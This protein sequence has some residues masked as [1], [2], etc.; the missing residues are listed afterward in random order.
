MKRDHLHLEIIHDV[1]HADRFFA[2]VSI[3]QPL[4]EA[5]YQY[6]L[7]THQIDARTHGFAKGTTPLKY[8]EHTIKIPILKQL[9][10]FFLKHLVLGFLYRELRAK[11]IVTAGHPRL[12]NITM[13]PEHNALFVFEM[14]QVRQALKPDWKAFSFKAPMRKN[15][16]D[17][18]RQADIFIKEET[19]RALQPQQSAIAAEDWI[20]FN[21]ALL[22]TH[23][24]PLFGSLQDSLWLK[25]GVEEVDKDSHQLFLGK[26]IGENY[27]SNSDFLRSYFSIQS[28]TV[29][30][31]IITLID[32]IPH[33]TFNFEEMK[34]FFGLK[35]TKDLHLKLIEVLSYRND[36]SQ[37]RET[38]EAVLRL[39]IKHH[40]LNLPVELLARQEQLIIRRMQ[41]SPDYYV[42]RAQRDFNNKIRLLAEKQL[43]EEL[44]ID[45]LANNEN[46]NVTP[47]DI[48]AYLNLLQR[49][50]TKEFIYFDPPMTKFNGQE[51]PLSHDLLIRHCLREKTLNYVIRHLTNKNI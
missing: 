10:E 30:H 31:F 9:K 1:H 40:P 3:D 34:L 21:V 8:L 17:L 49:P 11:N 27:I 48:R 46:I 36:M 7:Q 47:T 23:K 15:Y 16:K 43:K 45:G 12:H 37:R 19:E 32:R 26:M 33:A 39:L 38:A 25:I 20:N 35:S 6:T 5:L 42:Y 44:I 14:M 18:D 13:E 29:Y 50:R 4:V 41:L 28:G 51:M 2:H 24:K 22:D